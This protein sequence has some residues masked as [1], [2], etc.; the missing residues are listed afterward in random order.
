MM[1]NSINQIRAALEARNDRSAWA[2][3]VTAYALE[4]VDTLE[5]ATRGGWFTPEDLKSGCLVERCLLNGACS[6][7]QYSLGGCSY[8]YDDDIAHRLCTP[9]ELKRTKGGELPP[10]SR[11]QWINV[12]ARALWQAAQLVK[13]IAASI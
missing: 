2:K 9:S 3:G 8:I 11:E 7:D 12:Q 13:R 5:E 6:W 1:T 10:N 4:L